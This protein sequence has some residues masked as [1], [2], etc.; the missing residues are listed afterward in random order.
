[1]IAFSG[2]PRL[3][4]Y[5]ASLPAALKS[6][7]EFQ[8][9][10]AVLRNVMD[11][12]SPAKRP[13]PEPLAPLIKAPPK[14]SAWIPEVHLWA[15]LLAEADQQSM[16]EATFIDWSRR[17]NLRL[18]EGPVY[19][20]LFAMISAKTVLQLAAISFRSF[21]QGVEFAI[22]KSN[23]RG[24]SIVD[25]RFPPRLIN[26]LCLRGLCTGLE[27]GLVMAKAPQAKVVLEQTTDTAAR[28][29]ATWNDD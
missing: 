25:L 22:A 8:T 9:K 10:G 7:P 14:H 23:E 3:S 16:S 18:L 26:E 5:L 1:M 28:F 13:F 21:H 17:T 29:L 2:F 4:Q 19:K 27:A 20:F 24:G 6:Y 11:M 12:M 15:I